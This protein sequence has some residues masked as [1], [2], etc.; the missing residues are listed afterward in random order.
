[1]AR[2]GTSRR[3]SSTDAPPFK[4]DA[5]H[6]IVVLHGRETYLLRE[7]TR[8]LEE[9]LSKTLGDVDRFDLSGAEVSLADVLDELRS[10]GLLQQHKLVVLDE[11]EQFLSAG[12]DKSP[13][14]RRA[15][16]AYAQQP[17]EDT[18]L[19]MRSPNWRAGKL[20]KLIAKVGTVHRC[21]PPTVEKAIVWCRQR[22]TTRQGA[23]IERSA[24]AMLIEL[25][26]VNLSRLDME[27]AKLATYVGPGESITRDHV[28]M[29]VGET[30]EQLAWA[31]GEAI[32][33]GD[34]ADALTRL[35]EL[36]DISQVQTAPMMWS[37][38]DLA[39]KLHG[40]SAML[41]QGAG[42]GQIS[43]PMKLWGT[44]GEAV[45][46][47]AGRLT[48]GQAAQVLR[49]AVNTDRRT[50]SGIGDETRSLEALTVSVADTMSRG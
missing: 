41:A 49:Q 37:V 31:I 9:A 34:P 22:C 25:V 43:G 45:L 24:A 7:Y 1:M 4:A 6:R 19:L 28:A 32:C 10:Y 47:A 44:V 17:L 14:N 3:S 36:I 2:R 20:D 18:T 46:Q 12:G 50:K 35:R 21:D 13:R 48:P 33:T 39:R 16:E 5:S 26:D 11:A 15:M 23:E 8:Q 27:L 30:G 42:R 40:A 29:L 38:I